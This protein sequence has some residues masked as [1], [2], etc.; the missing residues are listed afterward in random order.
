[1]EFVHHDLIH[2]DN[3]FH[4]HHILGYLVKPDFQRLGDSRQ[5]FRAVAAAQKAN[6]SLMEATKQLGLRRS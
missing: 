1:M 2:Y 4:P 6:M 3:V 5:E